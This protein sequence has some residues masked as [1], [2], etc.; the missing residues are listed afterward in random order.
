MSSLIP[1]AYTIL[2]SDRFYFMK[3][4]QEMISYKNDLASHS[5]YLLNQ[6]L[7]KK[8]EICWCVSFNNN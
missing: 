2:F 8:H 1:H 3:N 6:K 4:M 7:S 5:N